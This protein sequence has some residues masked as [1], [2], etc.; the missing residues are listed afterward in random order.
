MWTQHLAVVNLGLPVMARWMP[1]FLHR[2][3]HKTLGIQ[4]K[5]MG[6]WVTLGPETFITGFQNGTNLSPKVVCSVGLAPL[7][8]EAAQ[9][10]LPSRI[11][12][13]LQGRRPRA[14]FFYNTKNDMYGTLPVSP[15]PWMG[16]AQLWFGWLMVAPEDQ[17]M[18]GC[19]WFLAWI[20]HE[21]EHVF[22]GDLILCIAPPRDLSAG[23]LSAAEVGGTP[24]SLVD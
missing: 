11:S 14:E 15:C 17:L 3:P 7:I 21:K 2:C 5:L 19:F 22:L 20:E 6:P 1:W 16:M 24:H 12:G 10:L 18:D 23:P 8:L 13:F 4:P 9:V